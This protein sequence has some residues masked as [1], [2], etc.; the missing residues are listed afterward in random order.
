MIIETIIKG[1]ISESELLEILVY[2]P[3][4][5]V[6]VLPGMFPATII[7]APNSDK[8]LIKPKIIPA[9]IPFFA[10]GKIICQIVWKLFK[11]RDL[12]TISIFLSTPDIAIIKDLVTKGK[13]TK[14][15]ANT[16]AN[17]VKVILIPNNWYKNSPK[18]LLRPKSHSKK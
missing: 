17:Q 11:P 15:D 7:V 18:I 1:Q 16:A 6:W 12:E 13:D 9:I 5:I 4:G 3:K 14:K 10:I 2:I 8:D